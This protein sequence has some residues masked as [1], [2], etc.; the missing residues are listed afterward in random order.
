MKNQIS[1]KI[2][3]T[4]IELYGHHGCTEEEQRRGQIIKVD[5]EMF[6]DLSKAGKTDDLDKTVDYS[7]IL[8]DVEKI[9]CDKSR[10]LIETVAE[11][12]AEKILSDYEKIDSLKVVLH[13]PFANLPINYDDV[14]VEIFRERK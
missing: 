5:L 7:K 6:L 14:A 13:K 11:E 9:V 4:G 3:L 10:K 2:V 8:L 1:D 12:I